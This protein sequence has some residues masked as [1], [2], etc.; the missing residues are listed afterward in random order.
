MI[1]NLRGTCG[2]GKSFVGHALARQGEPI[3]APPG[4]PFNSNKSKDKILGYQLPGDLVVLGRYE[5]TCGGMEGC[6]SEYARRLVAATAWHHKHV[7]FEGYFISCSAKPWIDH[8]TE[9]VSSHVLALPFLVLMLNTPFDVCIERV[10]A[11][12]SGK[13]HGGKTADTPLNVEVQEGMF[14]N[15]H[16]R[17]FPKMVAAPAIDARYLNYQTAYEDVVRILREEGGWTG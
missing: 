15:L 4:H 13:A 1:I 5:A 14:R 6:T 11:R 12:G 8:A 2:A 16:E 7:F 3:T 10:K 9:L 17:M